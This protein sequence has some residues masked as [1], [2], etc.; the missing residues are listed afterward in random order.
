MIITEVDDDD[1]AGE[2][3]GVDDGG[4]E[5][6]RKRRRKK[7]SAFLTSTRG[8]ATPSLK[9]RWT[10][11]Y[12]FNSVGMSITR[13]CHACD[14]EGNER[15]MRIKLKNTSAT[16]TTHAPLLSDTSTSSAKTSPPLLGHQIVVVTFPSRLLLFARVLMLVTVRLCCDT[17]EISTRAYERRDGLIDQSRKPKNIC[18][19]G[20][21]ETP[22]HVMTIARRVE[23]L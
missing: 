11:L 16:N 20:E 7:V 2:E 13:T 4:E 9:F 21:R 22:S 6:G 1:D 3:E 17:L 18:P 15:V 10:R 12:L 23:R 8:K 14:T 19:G 5:S